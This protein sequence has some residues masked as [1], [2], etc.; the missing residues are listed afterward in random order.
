[1]GVYKQPWRITK[2]RLCDWDEGIINGLGRQVHDE[3]I[4]CLGVGGAVMFWYQLVDARSLYLGVGGGGFELVASGWLCSWWCHQKATWSDGFAL[5]AGSLPVTKTAP[6]IYRP[7]SPAPVLPRSLPPPPRITYRRTLIV[8]IAG[9]GYNP[10]R[11]PNCTLALTVR[12]YRIGSKRGCAVRKQFET[13][14]NSR[15][16]APARP[17]SEKKK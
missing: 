2:L 9:E 8:S 14:K 11:F 16:A 12:H 13:R 4:V 6:E 7:V 3:L 10:Q 1:M 5:S 15:L 17:S